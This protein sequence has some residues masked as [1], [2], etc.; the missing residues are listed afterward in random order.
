VNLMSHV[1]ELTKLMLCLKV[2]HFTG[3]H[4]FFGMGTSQE[5]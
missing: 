1:I 2:L 5:R 4:H 3:R